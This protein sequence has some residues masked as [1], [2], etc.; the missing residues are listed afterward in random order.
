MQDSEAEGLLPLNDEDIDAPDLV[1]FNERF[2]FGAISNLDRFFSRM[3]MYWSS[4]GLKNLITE[5]LTAVLRLFFI[6]FFSGFLLLCVDW[7]QFQVR[8]N[9]LW[10]TCIHAPPVCGTRLRGRVPL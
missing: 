2:E 6:I 9:L 10:E 7:A 5:R 1:D 3:Y 8:K 4:G